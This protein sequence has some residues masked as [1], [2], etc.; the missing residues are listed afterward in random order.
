MG[1]VSLFS[2]ALVRRCWRSF[3]I[4][5]VGSVDHICMYA[6]AFDSVTIVGLHNDTMSVKQSRRGA[7]S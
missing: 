2:K 1:V 6:S 7:R 4:G 5:S 3:K